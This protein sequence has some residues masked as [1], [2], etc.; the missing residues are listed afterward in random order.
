MQILLFCRS[1]TWADKRSSL[2]CTMDFYRR[3]QSTYSCSAL[4]SCCSN[5][6]RRCCHWTRKRKNQ[7][8]LLPKQRGITCEM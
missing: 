6:A 2:R 1:G 3:R 8:L 7:T 4:K 5:Q